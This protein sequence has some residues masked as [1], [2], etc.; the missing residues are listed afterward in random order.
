MM[1]ASR[2]PS[3][4]AVN[5]TIRPS[6]ESAASTTEPEAKL[7][8]ATQRETEKDRE[9]ERKREKERQRDSERYRDRETDA[10]AGGDPRG[11]PSAEPIWR[12]PDVTF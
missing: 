6:G 11:Q 5:A 2:P 7:R 8:E 1:K 12:P 4:V 9:G 3:T 10:P